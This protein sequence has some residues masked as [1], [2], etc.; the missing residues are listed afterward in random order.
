MQ[1]NKA[2]LQGVQAMYFKESCIR[3]PETTAFSLMFAKEETSVSLL[4][5]G[6]SKFHCVSH[7]WLCCSAHWAYT[8]V[9]HGS[10]H[11]Q[12]KESPVRSAG[13]LPHWEEEAGDA[14]VLRKCCSPCHMFS[15][16]WHLPASLLGNASSLHTEEWLSCIPGF[17]NS[18]CKSPGV[19]EN[20]VVWGP[21]RNQ[22]S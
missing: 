3:P 8:E 7:H 20:V 10:A 17:E 13:F 6:P 16:E 2:V 1:V 12:A 15:Q 18:M 9:G 19:G 11:G 5:I 4:P 14:K 22:Y 21:E